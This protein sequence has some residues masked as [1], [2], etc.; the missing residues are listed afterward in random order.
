[1][2]VT[3]VHELQLLSAGAVPIVGHDIHVDL[4]VTPDRMVRCARPRD[5]R[6]PTLRWDEL[7]PEKIAS[8]PVLARLRP[9]R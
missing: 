9:A 2:V 6:I 5:W 8:I 3:T 7:T 4:V 1:V